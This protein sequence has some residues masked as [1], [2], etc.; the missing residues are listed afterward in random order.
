MYLSSARLSAYLCNKY[1]ITKDRTHT[2]GHNEVPDPY[3]PG[4]YGGAGHHTDPGK[5]C[6][7]QVYGL[8]RVLRGNG[9]A[10]THFPETQA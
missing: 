9:Y 1:G 8:R 4:Q 3:N 10:S 6:E 2:I 7:V 5:Y